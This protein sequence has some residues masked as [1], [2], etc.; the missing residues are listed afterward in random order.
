MSGEHAALTAI[1]AAV[2]TLLTA[3]GAFMVKSRLGDVMAS[4]STREE[5]A[6]Q[7]MAS[8]LDKLA[9]FQN[10]REIRLLDSQDKALE[11]VV[12]MTAVIEKLTVS[13]QSHDQST[14]ERVQILTGDHKE[15][16]TCLRSVTAELVLLRTAV[17]GMAVGMKRE[18]DAI[19]EEKNGK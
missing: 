11:T 6:V 18:R 10:E 5:T 7:Q 9:N 8:L 16:L 4:P 19:D 13:V 17:E 15:I 3:A 1:L 14:G 2:T 12:R